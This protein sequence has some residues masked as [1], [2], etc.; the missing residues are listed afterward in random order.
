MPKFYLNQ[1]YKGKCIVDEDEADFID[2]AVPF[3]P[4]AARTM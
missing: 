1:I 2:L 4:Q 3:L